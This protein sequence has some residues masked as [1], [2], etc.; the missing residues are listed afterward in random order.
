MTH[1]R[2]DRLREQMKAE[3]SDILRREMKDP[4]LGFVS[5]T[6]VEMSQDLRHAKVYVS[7]LGDE[8]AKRETIAALQGAVGFVR[9]EIGRRIRLRHTPEI[10]FKLDESIE[11]G[12]RIFELLEQI[13]GEAVSEGKGGQP[14][15]DRK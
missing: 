3:I 2:I 6:D 15:E 12:A 7:I 1:Y 9:T 4:R 10:V 8:A 5:V 13:K 14:E 11:R